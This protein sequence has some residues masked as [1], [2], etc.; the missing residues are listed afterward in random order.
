MHT[1]ADKFSLVEFA[2]RQ[3]IVALRTCVEALGATAATIEAMRRWVGAKT[4]VS[5]VLVSGVLRFCGFVGAKEREREERARAREKMTIGRCV[6]G[7]L[8]FEKRNRNERN[9]LGVLLL[10]FVVARVCCC[11]E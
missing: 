2:T 11:F 10:L 1:Y 3:T 9:A 5:L 8:F 6:G 4:A 7:G